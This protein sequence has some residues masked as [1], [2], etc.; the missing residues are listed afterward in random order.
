MSA[1]ALRLSAFAGALA[2]GGR[3]ILEKLLAVFVGPTVCPDARTIPGAYTADPM[4]RPFV[5][6]LR[7]RRLLPARV[8]LGALI[9]LGLLASSTLTAGEA[10]RRTFDLPAGDAAVTLKKFSAQSGEQLL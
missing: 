9:G 2:H 7:P 6:A 1:I 3:K 5:R 8:S 10:V 4:P